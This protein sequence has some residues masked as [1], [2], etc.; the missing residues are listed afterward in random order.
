MGELLFPA[1][2][3]GGSIVVSEEWQLK[4]EV[5]GEPEVGTSSSKVPRPK[6]STS[7][8]MRKPWRVLLIQTPA[9]PCPGCPGAS[10]TFKFQCY[11]IN[12]FP[13]FQVWN[14]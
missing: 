3:E 1:L 13:F 7:A 4:Q 10:R 11:Q 8:Q 2:P 14:S 12:L 6:G 5:E 9:V